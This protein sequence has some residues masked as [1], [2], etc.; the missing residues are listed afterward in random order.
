MG[1]EDV[2]DSKQDNDTKSGPQ[3]SAIPE[4]SSNLGDLLRRAR[5]RVEAQLRKQHEEEKA[6]PVTSKPTTPTKT[7]SG[8]SNPSPLPTA[9]TTITTSTPGA[10]N[11]IK[12]RHKN[13]HVNDSVFVLLPGADQQLVRLLRTYC[14][15]RSLP[16]SALNV[17]DFDPTEEELLHCK[18][19]EQV[20]THLNKTYLQVRLFVLQR[21]NN[22]L[23]PLL[24][25]LV[26]LTQPSSWDT[27]ANKVRGAREL[28]FWSH[29][30]QLWKRALAATMMTGTVPSVNLDRMRA[31]RLRETGGCDTRG[32][33]SVFGQAFRQL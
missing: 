32:T 15:K 11:L 23:A 24:E 1:L 12:L 26:D 28:I 13:F 3:G 9:P 14:E 16:L 6:T 17:R 4:T 7:F 5:Q 31:M 22:L 25:T 2:K 18:K 19:L 10:R 29:K 8:K 33:I 21:M 30:E 27:I 20:I